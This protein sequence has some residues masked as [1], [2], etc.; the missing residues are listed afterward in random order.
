MSEIDLIYKPFISEAKSLV[1]APAGHGK[2]HCIVESLNLSKNNQLILTHTN[3]GVASIKK[4][5]IKIG[6]KTTHSVETICGFAQK[7]VEAFISKELIPEQDNTDYF[8]FIISTAI[9]LFKR[10]AIRQVVK[11]NYSGLFVDEYQD[12]TKSQHQLITLLSEFLPTHILGD[13][14]QGIFDFNNEELVDFNTDLNDYKFTSE[15][16]TPWRW[17][18]SNK[19]LGADLQRMRQKLIETNQIKISD[20][21]SFEANFHAERD[22]YD[23]RKDYSRKLWRI[24]SREKSLLIIH[25]VSHN[26]NAR[27]KLVKQF[28]NSFYLVEAMDAKDFYSLAKKIDESSS[29]SIYSV[30]HEISLILFSKSKTDV[31]LGGRKLKNKRDFKAKVILEP[32]KQ[33]IEKLE[34]DFQL[35]FVAK[36][37]RLI[38]ELPENKCYRNELFH[39]LIKAIEQADINDK[40]VFDSM[41]EIRDSKRHIGRNVSG[42]CIGTTL[43]TKGLEFDT[44][45][46]LNAQRFKC[47][48]NLYV[49]LTRASRRL[50]IFSNRDE[51]SFI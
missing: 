22:L 47:P 26:L 15:L 49:A 36:A 31:W 23:F 18:N 3:A 6:V 11:A 39:D 1:V 27:T 44:V 13:P 4:K 40:S 30:I 46:I 21:K 17:E 41:K 37:L 12:C 43:L 50:I 28:K 34:K 38:K 33:I 25:P 10:K 48:K 20:Y 7:Y 2:T 5:V 42:K 16:A 45:I 24:I 32:L 51:I 8:P 29:A 9:D 35:R 14:L 19:D